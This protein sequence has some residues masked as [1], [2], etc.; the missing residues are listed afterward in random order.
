MAK[1]WTQTKEGRAR[2]SAIL[3]RRH[4]KKKGGAISLKGATNVIL[5]QTQVPDHVLAY[6]LGHVT[7]W[8]ESYSASHGL[9][10]SSI[11][12]RLGEVLYRSAR[13]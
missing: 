7:A 1:H 9:L 2:M 11:A 8:I 6:A 3:R 10:A 5:D 12:Y 4:A 13:R